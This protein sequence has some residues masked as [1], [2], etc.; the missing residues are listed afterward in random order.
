MRDMEQRRPRFARRSFAINGALG[1]P[2]RTRV[3]TTEM[4]EK[5]R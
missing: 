4:D 3:L 2:L 5:W 1:G